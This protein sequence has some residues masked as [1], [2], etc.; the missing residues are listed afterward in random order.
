MFATGPCSAGISDRPKGK[1]Q[2]AWIN[3]PCPQLSVVADSSHIWV[4][5]AFAWPKHCEVRQY[6]RKPPHR[7][8]KTYMTNLCSTIEPK[9]YGHFVHTDWGK[10]D[11]AMKADPG[12]AKKY[13]FQV[14]N[15]GLG[16]KTLSGTIVMQPDST[17]KAKYIY[18]VGFCGVL[19]RIEPALNQE[20]L[21]GLAYPYDWKT[22]AGRWSFFSGLALQTY[23]VPGQGLQENLFVSYVDN[24]EGDACTGKCTSRIYP[25]DATMISGFA[26]EFWIT[27][28]KHLKPGEEC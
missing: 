12:M 10:I 25:I 5:G 11:Q 20:L 3:N 14:R 8:E 7:H 18:G 26:K 22:V 27:K 19:F 15:P 4:L 17:G 13:P 21:L 24:P 23:E 6:A 28:K 9:D 1:G 2:D 16:P